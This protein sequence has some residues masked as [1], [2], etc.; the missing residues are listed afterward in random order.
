M[1]VFQCELCKNF[2]FPWYCEA[3]GEQKIPEEIYA[4]GY[5]H[6]QPYKGDNGIRFEPIKE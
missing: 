6:R 1:M 2:V 5:D 3:F 4:G